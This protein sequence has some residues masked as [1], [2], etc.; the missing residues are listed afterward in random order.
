MDCKTNWATVAFAAG[1][2]TGYGLKCYVEQQRKCLVSRSKASGK[3]KRQNLSKIQQTHQNLSLAIY[4]V[5][6][7]VDRSVVSDFNN[8]LPTHAKVV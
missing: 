3:G 2:A 4:S 1:V 5:D 6:V 8:W 7:S